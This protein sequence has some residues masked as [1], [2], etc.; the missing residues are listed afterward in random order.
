MESIS[1]G[2]AQVNTQELIENGGII[3][4][5]ISSP[6]GKEQIEVQGKVVWSESQKSYGIQFSNTKESTLSSIAQWTQG[7]LKT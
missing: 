7:L 2:G 3:E 1:L 6:D 4:M 5:K